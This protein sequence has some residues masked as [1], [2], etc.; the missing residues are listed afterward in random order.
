MKR[1][2][3]LFVFL[4][5]GLSLMAGP[6]DV[7][8]AKTVAQNFLQHQMG[9]TNLQMTE[10]SSLAGFSEIYIFNANNGQGYVIVSSDDCAKPILAYSTQ[11]SFP[12]DNI[13]P[14]TQYWLKKYEKQIT[15]AK[16]AKISNS[17][18]QKSW[19]A[20]LNNTMSTPKYPDAVQP[21]IT[22]QWNQQPYYNIY[23]PFDTS[24]YTN[25]TSTGCVATGMAQI[26]KYWN[27]PAHGYGSY[28]Y[29][30]DNYDYWHYG[31]LSADFQNTTYQWDIMPNKLDASS[32]TEEIN[33]VATLMYHVGVSVQ[34]SYNID[35]DGSSDAPLLLSEFADS[36][37]LDHTYCPENSL[38]TFFGYKPTLYGLS[39]DNY[40]DT[41]WDNML[42]EE[43]ALERPVLYCG[44]G[45]DPITGKN[46][47]GHCF[48][49]DGYDSYGF[50]HVNWGW[51]GRADD[52]FTTSALDVLIYSFTVDQGAIFGIEPNYEG[53]AVEDHGI[54]K[55]TV[56]A[57]QHQ[58]VVRDEQRQPVMVYDIN[59]RMLYQ[60][61][62]TN[63][64][65]LIPI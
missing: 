9:R 28:S 61:N 52:Y 65:T 11:E 12:I 46:N 4:F 53:V 30:W 42:R 40:V 22:T 6:V 16:S 18:T 17:T 55:P 25:H 51:G 60:N 38:P 41:V 47:G 62:H 37:Y 2:Y 26:M 29:N 13:A 44:S 58:I 1:F 39:R 14:A 20:L 7:N 49:L 5:A 3:S 45:I 54:V 59:G 57:R 64:E 36:M 31:T 32:T 48:I 50:F 33:A 27:W 10:V 15:W 35:G 43:I 34:M 63:V 8:T 23:C 24:L 19:K 56:F 21:L